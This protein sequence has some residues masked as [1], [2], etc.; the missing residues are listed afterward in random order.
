MRN[1]RWFT[2]GGSAAALT[3]LICLAITVSALWLGWATPDTRIIVAGFV[4]LGVTLV[5][6]TF[7]VREIYRECPD[8][9]GPSIRDGPGTG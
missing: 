3:I 6:G 4:L 5:A 7:M 9:E 8:E 2:L 1:R